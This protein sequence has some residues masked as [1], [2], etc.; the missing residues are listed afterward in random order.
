MHTTRTPP[1]G[2][3]G[4]DRAPRAIITAIC[5]ARARRMTVTH[6][7]YRGARSAANAARLR[8]WSFVFFLPFSPFSFL[9][10]AFFCFSLGPRARARGQGS[11]PL[12]A[13][14]RARWVQIARVSLM[15]LIKF[16]GIYTHGASRPSA[17][18]FFPPPSLLF[19][20][21]PVSGL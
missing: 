11:A 20:L 15:R 12:I 9:L 13:R 21:F 7:I 8:D 2:G 14:R 17:V 6:Y 1:P 4:G 19:F 5:D 3:G 10:P 18:L 16:P